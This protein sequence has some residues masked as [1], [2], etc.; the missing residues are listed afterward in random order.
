MT[1]GLALAGCGGD[2]ESPARIQVSGGYMPQPVSGDMA[3]GFLLI[4]NSGGSD[5]KLTSVTS[6]ISPAVTLH[7]TKNGTMRQQDS[8]EVPG[9][10]TLDFRRGG[11]HLM[12]EKLTHKP[13][14]GERVAVTL[15]FSHSGAV[16]AELPVK[17]TTYNPKSDA[18]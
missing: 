10:G 18:Q 11:N 4:S 8:F 13:K 9:D 5:D 1:A 15:H 16:D 6:K 7:S 12:F 14:L 2:H 17:A 3:A